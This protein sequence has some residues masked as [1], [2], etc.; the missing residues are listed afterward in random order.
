MNRRSIFRFLSALPL[1]AVARETAASDTD[2]AS[3][4]VA[5]TLA[6]AP[7]D[8]GRTVAIHIDSNP[9]TPEAAQWIAKAL[10]DIVDKS[11]LRLIGR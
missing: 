7:R 10:N 6:N 11:D 9:I 4:I 1:I 3:G 5:A 8:S 2:F